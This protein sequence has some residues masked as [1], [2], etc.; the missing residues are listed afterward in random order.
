MCMNL[1]VQETLGQLKL[2]LMSQYTPMGTFPLHPELEQR[3]DPEGVESFS[4]MPMISAAMIISGKRGELPKKVSFPISPRMKESWALSS[5]RMPSD[6]SLVAFGCHIGR[7][8]L[9]SGVFNKAVILHC[10]RLVC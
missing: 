2:S 10:P 6:L 1:C 7:L 3:V 8:P 9:V 4:I 5:L